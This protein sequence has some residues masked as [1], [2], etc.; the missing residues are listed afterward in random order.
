ME[1]SP[2]FYLKCSRLLGYNELFYIITHAMN[3]STTVF[4]NSINKVEKNIIT[5]TG[6]H[7]DIF[8]MQKNM[9]E[10]KEEEEATTRWSRGR[11]SI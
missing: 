9:K 10:E 2:Q 7:E 4:A 11:A 5:V 3:S 6:E 8:Y 1:F